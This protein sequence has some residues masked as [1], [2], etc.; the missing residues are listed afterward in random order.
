MQTEKQI[1]TLIN[2]GA[3]SLSRIC[4]FF[5]HHSLQIIY[6]PFLK[7]SYI[8]IALTVVCTALNQICDAGI[9]LVGFFHFLSTYT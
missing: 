7:H 9:N 1:S 8:V 2:I 6:F 5:P 3:G 4:H